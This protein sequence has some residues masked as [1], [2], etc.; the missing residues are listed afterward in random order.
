[1]AAI[2]SV[3][4]AYPLHKNDPTITA[5]MATSRAMSKN[6]CN[7]Y[8]FEPRRLQLRAMRAPNRRDSSADVLDKSVFCSLEFSSRSD[9]RCP[10]RRIIS[11]ALLRCALSSSTYN[12]TK[13]VLN[14]TGNMLAGRV[15]ERLR[16]M[17]FAGADIQLVHDLG[18]IQH[19]FCG[20]NVND[21]SAKLLDRNVNLLD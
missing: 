13:N 16:D 3:L 7:V 18:P 11:A 5:M 19:R 4:N 9:T 2:G 1:L 14:Q 17:V 21:L 8:V 20:P 6:L 12:L 15:A 10:Y